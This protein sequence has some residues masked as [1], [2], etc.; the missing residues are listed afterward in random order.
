MASA[1]KVSVTSTATALNDPSGLPVRLALQA[2]SA[3]IYVGGD[4]VDSTDGFKVAGT[5]GTLSVTLLPGDVLYA[6]T[7]STG[8]VNVLRT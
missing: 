4:D 2:A 3:D 7:A 5:S 6:V 1:E 8:T